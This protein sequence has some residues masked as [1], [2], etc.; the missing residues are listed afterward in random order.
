VERV[1]IGR[2]FPMGDPACSLGITC[3]SCGRVLE[4]RRDDGRCPHCEEHPDGT[5]TGPENG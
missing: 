2:L 1:M 4:A 5:T 3:L